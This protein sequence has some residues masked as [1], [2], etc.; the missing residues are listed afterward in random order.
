[1]M[2]WMK[3]NLVPVALVVTAICGV[4]G[5]WAKN[6]TPTVTFPPEQ[7][8]PDGYTDMYVHH[9]FCVDKSGQLFDLHALKNRSVQ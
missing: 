1:M 7:Q 5:Q 8:C 2:N 9:Y 6:Y 4:M 3:K